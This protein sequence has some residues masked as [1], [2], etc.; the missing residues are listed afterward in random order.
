[1][2]KAGVAK[3]VWSEVNLVNPLPVYKL[4]EFLLLKNT[5]ISISRDYFEGFLK[6][7]PYW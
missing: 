1:M 2:N 3:L 5:K 4:E 6:I 7:I